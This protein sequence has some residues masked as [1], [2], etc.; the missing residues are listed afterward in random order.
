MHLFTTKTFDITAVC[1]QINLSPHASLSFPNSFNTIINRI[2]K[3]ND[4]KL[5]AVFCVQLA[6]CFLGKCAGYIQK[7]EALFHVFKWYEP[8]SALSLIH[9]RIFFINILSSYHLRIDRMLLA[10]NSRTVQ[11]TNFSQCPTLKT[12][13]KDLGIGIF[14]STVI[15]RNVI[16]VFL[17]DKKIIQKG[18]VGSKVEY[19]Y[20]NLIKV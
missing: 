9:F 3:N 16:I 8:S 2:L 5:K 11:Q 1:F 7:K 10:G 15:R 6:N 4:S 19:G 12:H 20:K 18:N 14:G 17:E 13:V